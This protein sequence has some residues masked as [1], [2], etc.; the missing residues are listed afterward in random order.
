LDENSILHGD[1]NRLESFGIAIMAIRDPDNIQ[2]EL[3]APLG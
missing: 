3:T 2:I 1:I